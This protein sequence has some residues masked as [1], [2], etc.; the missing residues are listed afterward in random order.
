MKKL[1]DPEL[2]IKLDPIFGEP[3]S[4]VP[5]IIIGEYCSFKFLLQIAGWKLE[6][7]IPHLINEST[8]CQSTYQ[9][10]NRRTL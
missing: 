2:Y 3:E 7:N 6:R 10:K 1:P 8:I 5:G 4:R 9:L